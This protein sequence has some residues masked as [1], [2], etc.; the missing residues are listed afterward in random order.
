MVCSFISC[1]WINVEPIGIVFILKYISLIYNDLKDRHLNTAA[2]LRAL[3][4]MI[5]I[6]IEINMPI[7]GKHFF[8]L[9]M[10]LCET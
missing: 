3:I 8:P 7:K 5:N 1:S 6:Y 10:S 2:S 9:F 4:I